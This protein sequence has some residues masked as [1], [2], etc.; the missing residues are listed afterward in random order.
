METSR[1]HLRKWEKRLAD[2]A[3]ET[4]GILA[5]VSDAVSNGHQARGSLYFLF[6]GRNADES[7][8]SFRLKKEYPGL[9]LESWL[10]EERDY[11]SVEL[12]LNR[13]KEITPTA[14]VVYRR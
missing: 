9:D 6:R 2:M 7:D 3:R 11:G 4:P 1:S 14:R 12:F 8:I 5:I 13:Y 10:H